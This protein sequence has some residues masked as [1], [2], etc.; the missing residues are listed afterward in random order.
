M[1]WEFGTGRCKLSY[2]EWIDKVLMYSTGNYIQ[3]PVIY[4]NGKNICIKKE[5]IYVCNTLLYSRDWHNIV[6]QLYFN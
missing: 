4:H 3:Y 1:D 6:N 5:C 2:L